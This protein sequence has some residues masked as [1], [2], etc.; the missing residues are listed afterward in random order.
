GRTR[1]VATG[2]TVAAT[3]VTAPVTVATATAARVITGSRT[4]RAIPPLHNL[5]RA[6]PGTGR[7]RWA[8]TGRP[9]DRSYHF[10][11]RR[12]GSR[13]RSR[14]LSF[15]LDGETASSLAGPR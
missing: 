8:S 15:P 5:A 13:S 1:P 6:R 12:R 9:H 2:A 3:D 14:G 7:R 10:P 11:H 4:A